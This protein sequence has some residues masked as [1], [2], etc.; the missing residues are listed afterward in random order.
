M[1]EPNQ[2]LMVLLE[3]N[4]GAGKTTIGRNLD[5]IGAFRFIEEP[6]SVWQ[7]GY[8]ANLLEL[9]Y[10]DPHRWGFTFQVN[11]FMTRA[12]T[13]Y[14]IGRITSDERVILERSIYCDRHV[15]A[16]NCYRTG[17]ITES[18]YQLYMR[19]WEFLVPNFTDRPD[20]IL[21][22]RTPAELCLE[23]IQ[24]RARHEESSLPLSYLLELEALHD[25]WLL[26]NPAAIVLDGTR[27]WNTTELEAT[28]ATAL[29]NRPAP[30]EAFPL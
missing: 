1:A 14:E 24:A 7:E 5:A 11:A 15:F 19:M 26:D 3:G 30:M 29:A 22:L 2:R 25:E 28:I 10:R 18:E 12:K 23:R 4:I 17:L 13:W 21:Y 8:A 9:F 16:K 20:L 6:T 27:T